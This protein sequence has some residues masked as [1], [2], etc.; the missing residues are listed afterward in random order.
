MTPQSYDY[1]VVGGGTAGAV[2]AARLAEAGQHVALFEAGAEDENRP[3]ILT[4]RDWQKLLESEYDYDYTIEPQPRGNGRIRHARGKVLGGCSSHNSCIAFV[5]PDLDFEIWEAHG[6]A[7][8]G[9][10]EV[11]PYFERLFEKVNLETAAP[12]NECGRAMIAAAVEAGLP[13]LN[14]RENW[15]F[16]EGAGYFELNKQGTLRDS[17]SRAYLHPLS[18]WG[19]RLT[20]HTGVY[21][22]KV[23][24]DVNRR[25]IGVQTA[26]G[27]VTCTREVIVTCGVFDTPKLL[28]LSGIG[29]AAHLQEIGIPTCVDLPGVGENLLDHPESVVAWESA[30][31]MPPESSQFWEIGI[32]GRSR[33]EL[34]NPDIMLHF[35]TQVFDLQARYEGYPS[36]DHGFSLTPNVMRARSNGTVR[37]RG[38]DP[39]EPPLIDFRYFTDPAGYD[40]EVLV[41]GIKLARKIGRQPALKPWIKRELFPGPEV[42]SDAEISAYARAVANTVYHPAGTCKIGG[43]DDRMAVVD[44]SLR[45]RGVTGLRVA[46]ASV[47][48]TM[49]GVN[50]CLTVMMIGERCAA[51]ILAS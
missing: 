35:G 33:P 45:V 23:L 43:G 27:P 38:I 30:R 2:V 3:E 8:W 44:P 7:G 50:P 42:R 41:A 13:Q 39:A 48:P 18:Q 12:V 5:A 36:A 17:S 20:I 51:E 11:R 31:P 6:A 14:F 16:D 10:D 47:F 28:L 37:L 25:A 26:A 29:P 24:L 46:D 1:I 19:D 15:N 34:E 22:E 21:V 9:A 49:I 4:L 32:F 40:E